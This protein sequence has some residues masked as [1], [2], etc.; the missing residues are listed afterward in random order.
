MK[1]R[2]KITFWT[3]LF[4]LVVAI[5]FSGFVFYEAMEQPIRLI[6]RELLDVR[7]LSIKHLDGISSP[8]SKSKLLSEHPFNR[9]WIKISDVRDRI[10][11][12]TR[13]TEYLDFPQ[14]S[15][16]KFYFDKKEIALE[17]LWIAEED[18]YELEEITGSTVAFRVLQERSEINNNT[19][20]LLIARPIPILV[21]E[22]KELLYDFIYWV[23]FCTILIVLMSY[24]LSGR[25]LKPLSRINILVKEVNDASLH[26]RIPV[27]KSVDELHTLSSSLN[28]MFD[29]LQNS[30]DRQKEYIGNASHELNSPLTILMVG[31]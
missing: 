8:G 28:N 4:S 3:S 26:K 9:Y 21:Q 25:I 2:T 17:K 18:K 16:E 15:D 7:D 29:R 23:L 30:F 5:V 11:L 19:Y 20:D 1:A 22:V 12:K 13:L 27:G 31:N 24:Y 6:D 14:R 10:V